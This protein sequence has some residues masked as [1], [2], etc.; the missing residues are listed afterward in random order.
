MG[1]VFKAQHRRT[2]R[3][4]ALKVLPPALCRDTAMIARFQREVEAAAKLSH[5]NIVNAFDA[6]EDKGRHYLVME[7]VDGSDLSSVIRE[8]GP[9][10]ISIAIECVVQAARGLEYAHRRGVIHRDIKPSNLL[11]CRDASE[12]SQANTSA[13]MVP[14]VAVKI[15]DMGLAR[16][17]EEDGSGKSD[18]TTTGTVMGTVDFMSPE[19]ALDTRQ[20][21][22]QSDVYSLGCTLWY[23][24]IGKPV[25][26]GDTI[27]KRLVA[28][29]EHSIPSL[30][31]NLRVER[32]GAGAPD[33]G[34]MDAKRLERIAK[35]DAVFHKMVA[36]RREDRFASMTEVL[37]NL[38][39]VQRFGQVLDH[40]DSLRQ[41]ESSASR[42]REGTESL[43]LAAEEDSAL[44]SPTLLLDSS[45]SAIAP[46]AVAAPPQVAEHRQ[47][48]RFGAFAIS[49]CR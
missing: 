13:G 10:P 24:L 34:V 18:L 45:G 31:G 19:Q 39:V 14:N 43:R 15:L 40:S 6:D 37:Q 9:L 7:F 28:H 35:L 2:K 12:H 5:P 38:Q 47:P 25:F 32:S 42:D 49:R 33:S 29:R 21:D 46:Q 26:E 44:A 8:N 20:A 4:V 48:Q 17:E 16:F 36:K 22:A 1:Q 23:L 3:V 11:L 30:S 27:M 41:S